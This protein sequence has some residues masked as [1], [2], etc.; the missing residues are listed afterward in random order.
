MD[1]VSNKTW[2]ADRMHEILGL[3]DD[4]TARYLVSLAKDAQS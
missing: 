4:T 1:E 3:Y 2:L